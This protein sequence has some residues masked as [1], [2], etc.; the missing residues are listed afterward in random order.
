MKAGLELDVL[1]AKNVMGFNPLLPKARYRQTAEFQ[2]R[3]VELDE[4]PYSTTWE[5]M[6]LVVEGLPYLGRE[7]IRWWRLEQQPSGKYHVIL[8]DYAQNGEISYTAEAS[9]AP[10]SVCLAAL[11]AVGE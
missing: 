6:G 8:R 9:T 2:G 10:H 3:D 4:I 1:I 7:G 11:K 5:G